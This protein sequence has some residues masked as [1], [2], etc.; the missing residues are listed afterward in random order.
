MKTSSWAFPNCINVAQNSVEILEDETS[1]INRSRLLFLTQ[2]TEVVYEPNQGVG[3]KEFLWHYNN[4]NVKALL[5]DKIK[6]QLRI[7][8]LQCNA[9]NTE[10]ADGLLFTGKD[11]D[12]IDANYNDLD[13]TVKIETKF[14]TT[15][16]V[17]I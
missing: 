12:S 9:Q 11:K 17:N 15:A 8:E 14:G 2:P 3:M 13:M 1:V 5:R 16:T 10:F 6:N 7:H 4:E